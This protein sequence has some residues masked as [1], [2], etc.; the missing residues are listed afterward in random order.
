MSPQPTETQLVIGT[1]KG[2]VSGYCLRAG[3][4]ITATEYDHGKRL[5]RVWV[6]PP[7][8][9][10]ALRDLLSSCKQW[11]HATKQRLRHLN[12]R[13]EAVPLPVDAALFE[14]IDKA[15]GKDA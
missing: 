10:D 11:R 7:A 12:S 2:D 4:T 3:M 15:E 8:Q 13:H 14:A 9:A 5:L 6:A 1:D